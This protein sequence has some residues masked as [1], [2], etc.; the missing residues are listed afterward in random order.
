[1]NAS[2]GVTIM[3]SR[4]N[5]CVDL[6][7]TGYPFGFAIKVVAG[8]NKKRVGSAVQR[9]R[10]C[11]LGGHGGVRSNAVNNRKS[12]NEKLILEVSYSGTGVGDKHKL[13]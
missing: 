13:S 2:S 10:S 11:G 8:K 5:L 7:S 3:I 1:M 4:I 9:V 12:D 6:G